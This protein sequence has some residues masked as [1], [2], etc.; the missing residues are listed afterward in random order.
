MR[1]IVSA[2]RSTTERDTSEPV[3]ASVPKKL[4]SFN[5][6]TC[7]LAAGGGPALVSTAT[8]RLPH[9]PSASAPQINRMISRFRMITVTPRAVRP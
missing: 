6:T 5:S 3:M 4:S 9:P 2:F 7:T 1:P 8:S